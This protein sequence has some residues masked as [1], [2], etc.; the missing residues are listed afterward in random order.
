MCLAKPKQIFPLLI[1][2]HPEVNKATTENKPKQKVLCTALCSP[3]MGCKCYL[4]L[5]IMETRGCEGFAGSQCPWVSW[6][7]ESQLQRNVERIP[8][9]AAEMCEEHCRAQG[10]LDKGQ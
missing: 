7:T 10:G 3:L 5:H 8:L 9:P 2:L 4:V 1:F 6:R